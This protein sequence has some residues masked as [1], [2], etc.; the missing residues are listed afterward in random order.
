M[1]VSSDLAF[2]L[3]VAVLLDLVPLNDRVGDE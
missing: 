1:K 3:I 2:G